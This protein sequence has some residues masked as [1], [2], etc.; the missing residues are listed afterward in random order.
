VVSAGLGCE[1]LMG[2]KRR[3]DGWIGRWVREWDGREGGRHTWWGH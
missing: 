1:G 3:V 2:E